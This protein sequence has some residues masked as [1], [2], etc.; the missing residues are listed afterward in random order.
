MIIS[1]KMLMQ[2]IEYIH[3]NPVK[4]GLVREPEDWKYSSAS[5]YAG[6]DSIMDFDEIE[7]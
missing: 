4:A 5:Y 6:E 7:I 2:K 1:E 3:F